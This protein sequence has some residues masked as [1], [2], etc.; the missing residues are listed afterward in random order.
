VLD[1]CTQNI[2]ALAVL[3]ALVRR[4]HSAGG[5]VALGAFGAIGHA[6]YATRASPLTLSLTARSNPRGLGT[7]DYAVRVINKLHTAK[8]CDR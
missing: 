7:H 1:A 6:T 5:G 3:H 2:P 4:W 8:I